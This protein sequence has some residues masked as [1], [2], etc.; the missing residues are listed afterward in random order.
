M[1]SFTLLQVCI[2]LLTLPKLFLYESNT[3][4]SLFQEK[5]RLSCTNHVLLL[6]KHKRRKDL[7]ILKSSKD[8][9]QASQNPA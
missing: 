7:K 6:M 5:D 1:Q 8:L 9:R 2:P 3:Q 4:A